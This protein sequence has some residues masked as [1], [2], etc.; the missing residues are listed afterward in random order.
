MADTLNSWKQ[1]FQAKQGFE[2]LNEVI[3]G[4]QGGAV[5][6]L[7]EAVIVTEG[8][9]CT[10]T[11][12][13]RDKVVINA[14]VCCPPIEFTNI[15]GEQDI[16]RPAPAVARENFG[17]AIW[18]TNSPTSSRMTWGPAGSPTSFLVLGTEVE[19]KQHELFF[20]PLVIGS[21]Y[22]FIVGGCRSFCGDCASSDTYSFRVGVITEV[23]ISASWNVEVLFE[24]LT[25]VSTTLPVTWG[26]VGG[27]GGE[28]PATA[29][30]GLELLTSV[31]NIPG[32]TVL[33][34]TTSNWFLV[35]AITTVP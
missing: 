15:M 20:S 11:A 13:D 9:A 8:V 17:R 12:K 6:S 18:N 14:E 23:A 28:G 7:R 24:L 3:V 30:I 1:L 5:I 4:P 34:V 32:A 16:N 26:D 33:P 19:A 10:V 2:Q 25:C 29:P 22:E 21:Q 27:F 31:L 35:P